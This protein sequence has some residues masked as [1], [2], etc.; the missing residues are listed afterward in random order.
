MLVFIAHNVYVNE[1][2]RVSAQNFLYKNWLWKILRI[3]QVHKPNSKSTRVFVSD[4][5]SN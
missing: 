2:W 4:L 1:L 5:A 3:I